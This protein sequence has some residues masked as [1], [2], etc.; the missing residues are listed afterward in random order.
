[1]GRAVPGAGR[2]VKYTGQ[3]V[4]RCDTVFARDYG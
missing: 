3:M 4:Q 1:M 2:D